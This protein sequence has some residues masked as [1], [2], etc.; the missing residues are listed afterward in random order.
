ME[1]II[2]EHEEPNRDSVTMDHEVSDTQ[3]SSAQ[4]A[5]NHIRKDVTLR[6][7]LSNMDD[8]APIVRLNNYYSFM[9]SLHDRG[10]YRTDSDRCYGALLDTSWPAA[11]I[12][13]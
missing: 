12:G 4:P 9:L 3:Q 11:S 8:Y 6:E 13:S 1:D 7:F 5:P 10:R 2:Q